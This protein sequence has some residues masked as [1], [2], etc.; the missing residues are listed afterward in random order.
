MKRLHKMSEL[1]TWMGE[2]KMK[3]QKN[4]DT[5][6]N[7]SL[8]N[9][10]LKELEK[11]E[12]DVLSKEDEYTLFKA[13]YD[14]GDSRAR[15]EII[16]HNFRLVPFL[17]KQYNLY[18]SDPMDLVQ[19]GNIGLLEALENYN[20]DKGVRFATYAVF[21]VRKHIMSA[22]SDDVNKVYIP[23]TMNY[24][25]SKYKQMLEQAK[26][27][28]RELTDEEAMK[29]LKMNAT[30]FKTLKTAAVIEYS[31]L[32]VLVGTDADGK[33][34]IGDL[35]PDTESESLDKKMIAE[36]NHKLLITALNKL[37]P[38]EYDIVI[39]LY[40]FE[41]DKMSPKQLATKYGVSSERI[42]QICKKAKGKMKNTFN[43]EGIYGV[44]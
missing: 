13:F 14:K 11:P 1:G 43:K 16:K 17:I 27:E 44:E 33:T 19:A 3:M 20:P 10:Y 23:F 29:K 41:C 26:K 24:M 42:Y 34:Y 22:V 36:D 28:E 30:T 12:Y 35:I 9:E 5:T 18:T 25:V 6:N 21:V 31:S 4:S 15:E 2:R 40:G 39:H 38:R 37:T 7:Q 32:N 8:L